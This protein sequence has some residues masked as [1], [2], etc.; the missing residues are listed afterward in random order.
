MKKILITS[1]LA[2]AG[3]VA[4]TQSAHAGNST[5]SL[6]DNDLILGF[7][8]NG[9]SGQTTNLE[10]N[11][12][13]ADYFYNPTNEGSFGSIAPV[14]I[15]SIGRLSVTD[16]NSTYGAAGAWATRTDVSWGIVGTS[17]A[18]GSFDGIFGQNTIYLSKAETT[19]GVQTTPWNRQTNFG[20]ANSQI[21]SLGGSGG[22]TGTSTATSDYD[23]LVT[24]GNANSYQSRSGAL[25]GQTF[26]AVNGAFQ[27]DSVVAT[28][29]TG[30]WISIQDLYAL[31]E[32]AT[33]AGTYLG[34]FGLRADGTIDYA[35]RASEFAAV[36]EP[37][38]AAYG[39]ALFVAGALRRRRNRKEVAA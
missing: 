19:A 39:L 36:P 10:L 32:G 27:N 6:S 21:A 16:L 14:G 37:G 8:A 22:Y 4:S 31:E 9:N 24:A 17:S 28:F 1:I 25:S 11:L 5:V 23:L 13:S 15:T 29:S 38:T 34:S 20:A 12:G 30:N 33:T 3:V 2:L 35:A 26:G 7:R 18:F